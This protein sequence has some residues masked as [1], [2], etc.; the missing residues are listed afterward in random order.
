MKP[1]TVSEW[2]RCLAASASG[3]KGRLIVVLVEAVTTYPV[4]GL[5]VQLHS[6]LTSALE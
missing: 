1:I 6:F 5:Q 2:D 4:A 3:K